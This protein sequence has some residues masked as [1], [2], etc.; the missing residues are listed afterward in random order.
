MNN[1]SKYTK[2]A[3]INLFKKGIL[4]EILVNT[5]SNEEK[6]YIVSIDSNYVFGY[7]ILNGNKSFFKVKIRSSSTSSFITLNSCEFRISN[8]KILA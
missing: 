4:N 6:I 2:T 7:T 3:L 8:F 5:Q 1:L